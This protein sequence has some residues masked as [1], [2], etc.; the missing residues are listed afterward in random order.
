MG[1]KDK[2]IIHYGIPGMRWGIRR[3][4]NRDG[5]LTAAGRARYNPDG[6]RKK[7]I[8]MDDEDLTKSNRRLQS[9]FQYNQLTGR[10][11]KNRASGMDMTVKAGASA[12][13]SF[14]AVSGAML[15]KDYLTG[16]KLNFGKAVTPGLIA[17]VGGA[18]GSVTTSFGGQVKKGGGDR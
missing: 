10:H 15:L 8:D 9:E 3:F 11:Y 14:L 12:T 13:G 6:K 18:V 16:N 4:Q 7:A 17:A 1:Y 2:T 5:T